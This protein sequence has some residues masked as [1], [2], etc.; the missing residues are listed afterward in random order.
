MPVSFWVLC[1]SKC[2]LFQVHYPKKSK[3]WVCKVCSCNQSILK[4]FAEGSAPECRKVVQKLN[5]QGVLRQTKL[6]KYGLLNHP[7][8]LEWNPNKD[9]PGRIVSTVNSVSGNNDS[10]FRNIDNADVK[11]YQIVQPQEISYRLY[12]HSN[13][14][15]SQT[16]IN[17]SDRS[18]ISCLNYADLNQT[19]PFLSSRNSYTGSSD[20]YTSKWDV[21]L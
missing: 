18:D 10:L 16:T 3:T 11:E 6:S 9:L 4:V 15:G 21:Y 5:R 2:F 19:N 8:A 20:R 7:R 13:T 12:P 17:T 14:S 1:C